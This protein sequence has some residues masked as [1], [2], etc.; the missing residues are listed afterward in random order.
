MPHV[1]TAVTDHQILEPLAARWSPY[2][3]DGRAV[4]HDKLLAC[5][6]A[7]RWAASS[8]NEQPWHFLLA[9][10]DDAA[11]FSRLL[12]CLLEANQGW[13]ANAGALL[14]TVVA[15]SFRRNGSPNRVAEHDL[16]L[17]VGNLSVQAVALG[18]QT[19]QMAGVNLSK[20]RQTYG[21]PDGFEPVTVVAIGYPAEL[22]PSDPSP[23]AERDRT[24]RQRKPLRDFVFSGAWQKPHQDV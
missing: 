1:K 9:T 24:A 6:E 5:L 12:S 10:R 7:A 19:H 8:Y 22:D 17:A 3:F 15:K 14:L 18:L 23:L 4:E 2:A 16:G 21:I 11:E 20:A 13:A